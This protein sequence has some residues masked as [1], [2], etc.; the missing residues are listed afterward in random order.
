MEKSAGSNTP[1]TT[2]VG[3]VIKGVEKSGKAQVMPLEAVKKQS[4][5]LVMCCGESSRG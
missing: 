4:P 2:V 3:A 1:D 5:A